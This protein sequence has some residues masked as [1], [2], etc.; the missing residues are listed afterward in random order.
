MTSP[1][2][3]P[4]GASPPL[5]AT[6]QGTINVDS[7]LEVSVT[8]AG[9]F[10]ATVNGGAATF[11]EESGATVEGEIMEATVTCLAGQGTKVAR[12]RAL[13]GW[14]PADAATAGSRF[15]A[16]AMSQTAKYRGRG[17]RKLA[18]V[19]AGFATDAA[20]AARSAVDVHVLLGLRG[21]GR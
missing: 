10:S 17:V 2:T 11:T 21:L 9:V 13:A 3:M 15:A 5:Y 6:W 19:V 1:N 16:S 12:F 14:S 4:D 20:G 7:E 18:F 8:S